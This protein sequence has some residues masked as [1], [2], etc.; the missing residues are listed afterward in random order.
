MEILEQASKT[1]SFYDGVM[2]STLL[3]GIF[4]HRDWAIG[5][6]FEAIPKMIDDQQGLREDK[7]L[8]RIDFL[9]QEQDYIQQK[10]QTSLA[11][12]I[13]AI[14]A[15]FDQA[16]IDLR[17]MISN[18]ADP[19]RQ[20]IKAAARGT[21]SFDTLKANTAYL[22][23]RTR[24]SPGPNQVGPLGHESAANI[25][26]TFGRYKVAKGTANLPVNQASAP[27]THAGLTVPVRLQA[28]LAKQ[29]LKG[30]KFK[31]K[32]G[33]DFNVFHPLYE[34][35]KSDLKNQHDYLKELQPYLNNLLKLRRS[36]AGPGETRNQRALISLNKRRME[37]Q[38]L[39]A[40]LLNPTATALLWADQYEQK[41]R[42]L[43]AELGRVGDRYGNLRNNAVILTQAADNLHNTTEEI[44]TL[45]A[46]IG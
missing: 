3:T 10:V 22:E 18:K 29:T 26:E 21:Q 16:M 32:Q 4:K 40:L 46:H 31:I 41:A 5:N 12:S 23:Q 37:A 14:T 27:L 24:P 33:I 38:R 30:E 28:S 20:A 11:N 19:R 35:F 1:G 2:N 44:R 25:V 13:P 39:Q 8:G 36:L 45:Y 15:S 43:I 42:T 6:W 9:D 17:T 7:K 34:A